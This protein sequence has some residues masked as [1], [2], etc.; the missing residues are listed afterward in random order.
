M[1]LALLCL[2]ITFGLAHPHIFID[3]K[4]TIEKEKIIIAWV[5]DE[6]TSSVLLGDYDKNKNKTLEQNEI[7]F[8][9][10][11]H[12]KP[13]ATYNFFSAFVENDKENKIKTYTAFGAFIEKG[14]LNYHFE[15]PKPQGKLY[16][17]HFYD[18]EMYVALL[19]NKKDVKCYSRATCKSAGYDADFYYGYKVV[20][21]EQ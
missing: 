3:T 1:K 5:F 9:E 12:F 4:V 8:M 19:V 18:P 11:D 2:C 16:E 20:I 15:I 6:M 7:D 14:R 10:K 13:L 21:E 17:I